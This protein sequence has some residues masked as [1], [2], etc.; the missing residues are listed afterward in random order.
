MAPHRITNNGKVDIKISTTIKPGDDC[1]VPAFSY[2]VLLPPGAS[3]EDAS[4]DPACEEVASG[5]DAS[6][7]DT[8]SEAEQNCECLCHRPMNSDHECRSCEPEFADLE[9]ACRRQDVD[10]ALA[11]L[12][13]PLGVPK[14]KD[15]V[16]LFS[17]LC[18]EGQLE[19]AEAVASRFAVTPVE[20]R[21]SL[22]FALRWACARGHLTTAIWLVAQFRLVDTDARAANNFALRNACEGGHDRVVRWL[23][24]HFGLRDPADLDGPEGVSAI[25][26]ARR[27]CDPATVAFLRRRFFG[28]DS[29]EYD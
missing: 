21:D 17:M 4:L 26:L 20:A 19:L 28:E 11:I 29:D 3:C 5:T 22:N 9:A 10:T 12:D 8:S 14:R 15:V 13:G 2:E 18:G 1:V 23:V 16:D 27:G 24:L 7:D 6:D 25:E